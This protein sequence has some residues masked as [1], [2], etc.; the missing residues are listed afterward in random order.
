MKREINT[1]LVAVIAIFLAASM[2]LGFSSEAQVSV[3]AGYLGGK[4]KESQGG[5]SVNTTTYGFYAGASC[6]IPIHATSL[7]F[8]PGLF[9]GYE[10]GAMKIPGAGLGDIVLQDLYLPLKF[11]IDGAISGKLALFASAGPMFGFGLNGEIRS[12]GVAVNLFDS[13]V[14]AGNTLK[15]FDLLFGMECGMIIFDH[16]QLRLGF[17]QGV[18]D[19]EDGET[20]AHRSSIHIGFAYGF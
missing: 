13:S 14:M 8:D 1:N 7:S 5:V 3:G 6:K 18:L 16:Y 12:S 2:F 19:V 4:M 9:Y 10:T 11:R 15:R 20:T 17:D